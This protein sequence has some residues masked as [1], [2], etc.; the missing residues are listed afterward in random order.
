MARA[1][2]VA[3]LNVPTPDG[4]LGLTDEERAM[5]LADL[6]TKRM[7]DALAMARDCKELTSVLTA[8]VKWEAVQ[9]KLDP[10]S[11]DDEPGGAL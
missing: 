1:A 5:S 2:S 3:E 10:N 6:I 8:A 4:A 7:K 9:R 11:G